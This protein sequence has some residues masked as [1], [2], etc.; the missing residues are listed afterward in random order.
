VGVLVTIAGLGYM[1]NGFAMI[2]APTFAG[3]LFP[4][5]AVPILA[6]EASL[7]LW[8]LVKGVNA[9]RWRMQDHREELIP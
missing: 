1:A 3:A 6:G 4:F 8:L 7:C 9:E 5:V 2:L